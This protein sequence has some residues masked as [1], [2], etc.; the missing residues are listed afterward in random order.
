[1]E[2]QRGQHNGKNVRFTDV[3]I[4]FNGKEEIVRIKKITFGENLDIRQ[5]CSKISVVGGQERIEIDQQK[6]SEECL[7]TSIIQ[8]PFKIVLQDIRDLDMEV[9]E[10]LLVVYRELNSFDSKKKET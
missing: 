6:L 9:G 5:K 3:S 10:Q 8:A 2:I 4:D 7:L 1:M